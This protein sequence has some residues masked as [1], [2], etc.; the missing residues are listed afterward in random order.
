MM[1]D[2]AR[3]LLLAVTID[4]IGFRVPSKEHFT[5]YTEST[6][7]VNISFKCTLAI[8]NI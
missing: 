8:V 3:V 2:D 1:S 6:F 4:L 7:E 5:F